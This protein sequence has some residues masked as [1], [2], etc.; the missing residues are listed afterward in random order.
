M[1][2]ICLAKPEIIYC[3][4]KS[5]TLTCRIKSHGLNTKLLYAYNP[6]LKHNV[7]VQKKKKRTLGFGKL[8]I[9]KDAMTTLTYTST[10]IVIYG[11][12]KGKNKPRSFP[13]KPVTYITA[14]SVA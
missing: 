8:T 11:L 4:F 5:K 10:K 12:D 7:K 1:A 14:K 3:H 6:P 13:T 2:H 9:V